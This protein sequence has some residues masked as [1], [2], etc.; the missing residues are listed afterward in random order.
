MA[1]KF[2]VN[3]EPI[4]KVKMDVIHLTQEHHL[5]FDWQLAKFSYRVTH[6][7]DVAKFEENDINVMEG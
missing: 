6:T 2:E 5:E 1:D 7:L 4:G 3:T